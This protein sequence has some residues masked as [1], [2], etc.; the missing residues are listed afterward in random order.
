[1]Y[2]RKLELRDIKL[3]RLKS[4]AKGVIRGSIVRKNYYRIDPFDH[5]TPEETIT[6]DLLTGIFTPERNG[7]DVEEYYGKIHDWFIEILPK[8]GIPL[9]ILDKAILKITPEGKECFIKVQN[10]E[11]K[12]KL[13]FK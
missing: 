1:M 8:E 7:D 3:N 12:E 6:L 4:V 9:N 11:F 13:K 2:K 10:K 5:Y